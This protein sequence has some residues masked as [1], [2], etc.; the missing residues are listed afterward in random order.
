[1]SPLILLICSVNHNRPDWTRSNSLALSSIAK[2]LR[3]I[4]KR[5]KD[6]EIRQIERVIG[7]VEVKSTEDIDKLVHSK[8]VS[9]SNSAL[10]MNIAFGLLVTSLVDHNIKDKKT[11][12]LKFA[13]ITNNLY[14]D[15]QL[16]KWPWEWVNEK[17]ALNYSG[18]GEEYM[19]FN[20]TFSVIDSWRTLKD[21]EAYNILEF[22]H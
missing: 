21:S 4:G 11:L 7:K 12:N 14:G 19:M 18:R 15:Y 8:I 1:M 16:N 22:R 3:P 17:K 9:K 2:I 20:G 13:I 10:D 5:L 6:E